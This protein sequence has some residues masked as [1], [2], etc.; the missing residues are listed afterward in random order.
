MR[1]GSTYLH[2]LRQSGIFEGGSEIGGG[3]CAR[4][5]GRAPGITEHLGGDIRINA[6]T[7]EDAK[8]A[9]AGNP[10]YEAGGTVEIRERPRTSCVFKVKNQSGVRP[11]L[12]ADARCRQPRLSGPCA[13]DSAEEPT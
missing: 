4:K 2:R 13:S 7:I 10:H 8:Q 5:Q 12:H 9:L 11:N 6:A 3:I 1:P